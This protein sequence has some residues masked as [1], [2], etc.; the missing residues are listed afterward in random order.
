[1]YFKIVNEIKIFTLQVVS[2]AFLEPCSSCFKAQILAE[3][4]VRS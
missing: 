4:L 2:R 3:K 1:M